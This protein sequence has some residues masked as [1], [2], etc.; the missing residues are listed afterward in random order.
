M[1]AIAKKYVK[2]L[3]KSC[4]EKELNEASKSLIDISSAFLDSKFKNI[5]L[6]PDV[7][8]D[9]KVKLILSFGKCNEKVINLIK[10]LN[11]NDRLLDIPSISK[12][13]EFKI[14]EL[15]NSY[16][17]LIISNFE[18]SKS[19]IGELESSFSKKFNAT[20]KLQNRVTDYP[21]IKVE[22]DNLGVE[23]SFSTSRLKAQIAEHILKAI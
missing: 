5:V 2:A 8:K 15:T 1:G 7:A 17:G 23:V 14:S 3:I 6:S 22:I 13:L 11:K 16:D 18:V 10:T 12:E 21:G 19:K 9:D 20:I 4:N